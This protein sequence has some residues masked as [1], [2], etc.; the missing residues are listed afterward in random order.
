MS[1]PVGT[2][3]DSKELDQGIATFLVVIL[4]PYIKSATEMTKE[5][6]QHAWHAFDELG[7]LFEIH[8]EPYLVQIPTRSSLYIIRF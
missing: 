3:R 6:I 5:F 1:A 7:D 4:E 2:T 8:E